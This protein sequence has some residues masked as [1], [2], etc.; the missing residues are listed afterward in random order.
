M[1]AAAHG[2]RRALAALALSLLSA[3]FFTQ[4]YL[5]NRAI[6]SDGGHWAWTASLRYLITLPL[7]LALMPWQGGTAPVLRAIRAHPWA[8]LRC[9]AIGF[10]AFYLALSYAADR[11][12]SWL[13]AGS[14]QFTVV[15]GMLCAPFLYR[16]ARRR[17]HRAH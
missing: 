5:L 6:A 11:G 8:W 3:L 2:R 12:P 15:A 16:D 9:G 14:F 7:L 13:I 17:I 1:T 10:V 4:T